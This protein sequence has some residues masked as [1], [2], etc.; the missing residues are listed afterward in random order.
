[1]VVIV[2]FRVYFEIRIELVELTGNHHDVRFPILT[3]FDQLLKESFAKKKYRFN[4]CKH[5]FKLVLSEDSLFSH[6]S[7]HV[8]NDNV[9]IAYIIGFGF[10]PLFNDIKAMFS[11]LS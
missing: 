10:D 1:M 7:L 9:E 5:D 11:V 3:D 4:V 2:V 8:V 6:W